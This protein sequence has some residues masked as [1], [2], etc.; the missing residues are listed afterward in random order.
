MCIEVCGLS[1]VSVC[2]FKRDELYFGSGLS[3]EFATHFLKKKQAWKCF[4]LLD[5]YPHH[6]I[7]MHVF[8]VQTCIFS[9][10]MDASDMHA[11]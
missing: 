8:R 2:A 1:L 4:F 3:S 7:H 11:P 5:P 6:M 9:G 10:S